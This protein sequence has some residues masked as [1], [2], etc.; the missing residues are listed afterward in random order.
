MIDARH[1]GACRDRRSSSRTRRPPRRENSDEGLHLAPAQRQAHSPGRRRRPC[2]PVGA[3]HRPRPHGDEVRMRR[4][5][6]RRLH[7][8]RWQ[9]G[10]EVV[11]GAGEGGP[12]QGRD[13]DRG[14]GE[15]REASPAP[16]GVRRHRGA[17]VRLLHPRNDHECLRPPP[18]DVEADPEP[19]PRGDGRQPVPLRRPSSNRAGHRTGF[20]PR[21]RRVMRGSSTVAAPP[22]PDSGRS[23]HRRD[24]I[25][26]LGGGIIVLFNADLSDL[27]AQE[28]R[29]RGY[30]TDF[31]AYLR[32]AADGRVTI[33]SGKIEMGQGVVTSLAQMAA[34]ELAVSLDS[35]VMV[36]GDT[37]LCPFDNGTY[38]SMSTRFFGPALRSAAAEAKAV[39]LDLASEQLKT[40]K[41][42]L[43][44]QNGAV[45]VTGDKKARLTFGQLAKGQ[46]ITRK[47]EGKAVTKSVAEFTIV[48]KSPRRL[49]AREKVTGKAQYAGD[50]RIPG[51]VYARIL[52]PPAHEA[53]LKTVDTAPAAKVPGVIVVNE[54]GLVAVLH[55][56]PEIAAKALDAVKADWDVP[57]PT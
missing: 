44:V 23:L 47:P 32:I 52:R 30:P 16:G 18:Q 45:F 35:I 33:Y 3:A 25:R 40:P 31:N 48:G 13:D 29:T 38:G 57:A 12:R 1:G 50:I 46:K 36:M 54:G 9:R 27:L 53:R 51:M 41:D 37:A 4:E 19:D 55:Q 34:D 22:L 56:D 10:G 21:V 17:A 49:D 11:S 6:L 14:P 26:L 5:L 8:G 20:R 42:K 28:S 7:R 15:E 24:F 2:A 39:L 43:S